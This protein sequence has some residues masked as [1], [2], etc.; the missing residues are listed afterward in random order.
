MFILLNWWN[1]IVTL[2]K[3]HFSDPPTASPRTPPVVKFLISII[4]KNILNENYVKFD[5]TRG[6]VLVIFSFLWMG[7]DILALETMLA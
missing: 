7:D 6:T 4:E 1:N 3:K 5:V 2:S